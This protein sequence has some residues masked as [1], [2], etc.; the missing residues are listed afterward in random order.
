MI[1]H[2]RE[3]FPNE[4]CGILAGEGGVPTRFFPTRNVDE[5]PRIRYLIDPKEQLEVLR[6]I[7]DR[8][9]ELVGIFHS[10][11]HT[12][13]YPSPTD[14]RLAGYPEAVFYLVS[15]INWDEPELRAY[16]ILDDQIVELP[17]ELV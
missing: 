11:T 10:H 5:Q 15:L 13:A 1:A 7:D 2:A 16:R 17:I 14:V 6:T 9:E 4:A 8:G 12:A 3:G